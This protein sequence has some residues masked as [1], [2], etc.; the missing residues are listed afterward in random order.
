M[1]SHPSGLDG[2][3]LGCE[4]LG[5]NHRKVKSLPQLSCDQEG[6]AASPKPPLCPVTIS[7]QN[8]RHSLQGLHRPRVT[9][10]S[11]GF[12]G[13]QPRL[14]QPF[15]SVIKRN[16]RRDGAAGPWRAGCCDDVTQL[17]GLGSL[18][19]LL[20]P[21]AHTHTHTRRPPRNLQLKA[22][23]LI[24]CLSLAARAG[25]GWKPGI[26]EWFRSKKPKSGSSPVRPCTG[27]VSPF[28]LWNTK[29]LLF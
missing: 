2:P 13:L 26:M 9:A 3:L 15:P 18:W 20:I 21:Q 24:F 19:T 28:P 12:G 7:Q 11:R 10:F 23:F 25:I 8:S 5:M 4:L 27:R 16:Q 17:P 14:S 1:S 6:M 22:H 29:L